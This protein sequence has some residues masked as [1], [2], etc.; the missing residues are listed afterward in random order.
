MD[1]GR[2][3]DTDKIIDEAN[4]YA[5]KMAGEYLEELGKTDVVQLNHKEWMG[6]VAVLTYNYE[7]KKIELTP[8]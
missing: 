3:T 7:M 1:G 2:M 8:E 4:E 5:S 6:F